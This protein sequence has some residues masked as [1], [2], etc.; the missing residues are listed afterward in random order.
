VAAGGSGR[1]RPPP[2]TNAPPS[3]GIQQMLAMPVP[4]PPMISAIALP[5]LEPRPLPQQAGDD[6][7]R[8]DVP[9]ELKQFECAL[10]C[11]YMELP[12]GCGS[13]GCDA[14]CCRA[15]LARVL[16]DRRPRP[17]T[18]PPDAAR[19]PHCRAPF[20][21]ESMTLDRALRE[22]I[23]TCAVPVS[24]PFAGC[25]HVTTA[26][27]LRAHE[28]TCPHVRLRCRYAEHGCDWTG[29]RRDL[30]AH[31]ERECDFRGGLGKLLERVRRGDAWSTH[32]LR[33]H[34]LQL[35][36]ASQMLALQSRQ[37]MM[38]RARNTGNVADVCQ[39][40]YEVCLY[41]GRFSAMRE[42]WSGMI[43]NA[44]SRCVVN[45]VLLLLPSLLLVLRISLQGFRILCEAS[46]DAISG[47]DDWVLVDTLL[48]AFIV[49][50]LGILLGIC[51][52]LDNDTHWT[53]YNIPGGISP[54]PVL[55]NLAA[56]C[57][58]MIHF[59]AIEFFGAHPGVLLWHCVAVPTLLH[60]SFASRVIE[61]N[62]ATDS[63][64]V[65]EAGTL[66][67]SRAWPVVVFGLRYGFVAGA[68]GVV[69]TLN[70]AAL[71]R[72]FQQANLVVKH[73]ECFLTLDTCNPTK[74]LAI[75][76][77][78]AALQYDQELGANVAFRHL[79]LDGA[80]ASLVLVYVNALVSLLVTVG[81]K[82]GATNFQTGNQAFMEAHQASGALIPNVQPTQ[83]GCVV[84]GAC[85]FLLLCVA[86]G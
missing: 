70:A 59:S 5:A 69:P 35:H 39:L 85:S 19:C 61:M 10:C 46:A 20:T 63:S 29:A 34:H 22:R 48:L 27:R 60:T 62:T 68:C 64:P 2:A 74:L 36:A 65:S 28:A 1:P 38:A 40:S 9:E 23:E 77:L 53:V 43:N 57:L 71:L 11:E 79:L 83:V 81:C 7:A 82:M 86:L 8:D 51:F 18:D 4:P 84:F 41:P 21:L 54:Q 80:C 33:Q 26:G 52:F 76:S 14:R 13:P 45:S 30:A 3:N 31:E 25:G 49:L 15:C 58:A 42:V 24:C 32:L 55:R 17:G 66:A 12:A 44:E 73:A 16:R 6:R 56:L 37:L 75:S 50:L 72:I 67:A 78:L 47:K